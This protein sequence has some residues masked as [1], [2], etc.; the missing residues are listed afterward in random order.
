M[1]TVPQHVAIIMDGNGRWAAARGLSREAG[2]REGLNSA[3]RIV[4]QA[5]RSEVKHLTL[6]S[7]STENWSR[8]EDEVRSLMTLFGEFIRAE[9]ENP[10]L[11]KNGVRFR[12]V[13]DLSR[14]SPELRELIAKLVEL[15]AGGERLELNLALNYGGREDI[16]NAAKQAAQAA[17][18]GEVPVESFTEQYLA[19]LLRTQGTPDPDLLIRTGGE[20][21]ISNFLLWQ[22]SYAELIFRD[23]FWPD[24]AEE[25]FIS[26]LEEFAR[27]QRRFGATEPSF[28]QRL[29]A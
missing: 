1:S 21:R 26:S 17:V 2:H 11:S 13:G 28:K 9:F 23:E 15:T 10:R 8:P 20:K 24:F 3:Q 29:N 6:Y 5:V 7:F 12:P 16:V 4:E 14:F 22:L 19:S 27:R 25:H 18:N